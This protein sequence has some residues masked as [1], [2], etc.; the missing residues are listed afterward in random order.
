MLRPGV[1]A[2]TGGVTADTRDTGAED[3]DLVTADDVVKLHCERRQAMAQLPPYA[4]AGAML[5]V[6]PAAARPRRGRRR[7]GRLFL[8]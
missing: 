2:D 3:T 8:I 7:R 1:T 5:T 6:P 4:G